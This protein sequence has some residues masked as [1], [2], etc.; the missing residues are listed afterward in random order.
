[1]ILPILGGHSLGLI[2]LLVAF[3]STKDGERLCGLCELRALEDAD[4]EDS[5]L[6]ISRLICLKVVEAAILHPQLNPPTAL[7]ASFSC[8]PVPISEMIPLS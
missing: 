4:N 5:V 1:M 8:S 7:S 3:D 2:D 6:G